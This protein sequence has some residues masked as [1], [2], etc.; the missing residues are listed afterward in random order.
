MDKR[1][2]I[3]K[4]DQKMQSLGWKFFAPILHYERAWK[5]QAGIY[6]KNGEYVV[7]G[8]DYTGENEL[9]EPIEKNEA[10]RRAEESLEEIKDCIFNP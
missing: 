3:E 9:Y 7:S 6:E 8:L 5:N 1:A 10:I 4:I 2:H